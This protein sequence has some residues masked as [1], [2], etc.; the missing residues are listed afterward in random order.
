MENSPAS[1][2]GS[3]VG[4]NAHMRSMGTTIAGA[5]MAL[6]LTS[7]MTDL[8][9]G[10]QIPAQDTF[11]LCFLL[12]AGAA[13]VGAVVVLFLPRRSTAGRTVAPAAGP[14]PELEPAL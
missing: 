2:A 3:G 11:H 14:R 12:G 7:R 5:V 6:V 4:V 13:L 8:G 1:E 10:I 9:S